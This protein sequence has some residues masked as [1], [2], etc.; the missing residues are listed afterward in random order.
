[1]NKSGAAPSK[2]PAGPPNLAGCPGPG[3]PARVSIPFSH[4]LVRSWPLF[5]HAKTTA[6]TQFGKRPKGRNSPPPT[7]PVAP[8]PPCP[9]S[10][11]GSKILTELGTADD[12][13]S[14]ETTLTHHHSFFVSI[15]VPSHPTHMAV[16]EALKM[17]CPVVL[18]LKRGL[19]GAVAAGS[20][21]VGLTYVAR[22]GRS[23]IVEESVEKGLRCHYLRFFWG[24]LEIFF[25]FIFGWWFLKK[26]VW[27]NEVRPSD[28]KAG[29]F[30]K[31][32]MRTR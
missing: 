11:R 19:T 27:A 20:C 28:G 25:S 2:E 23:L 16:K 5:S 14:V 13:I 29:N 7:F 21:G 1:M 15:S 18:V 24:K 3:P 22:V 17:R 4:G 31:G 26:E 10:S 30:K 9:S 6:T 12:G 32:E 8:S